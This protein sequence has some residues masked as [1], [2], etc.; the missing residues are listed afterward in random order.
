M[1]VYGY[2]IEMHAAHTR[3][4]AGR[5]LPLVLGSGTLP[6]PAPPSPL[7]GTMAIGG[8]PRDAACFAGTEAAQRALALAVGAGGGG[9]G[10][11]D[12][13]AER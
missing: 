10:G 5:L 12:G 6:T 13:S 3:A 1:G 2:V 8:V 4:R 11:G 9:D 7:A